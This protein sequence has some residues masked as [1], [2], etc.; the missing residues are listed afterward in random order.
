LAALATDERPT[1]LEIDVLHP[2]AAGNTDKPIAESQS[3]EL[4]Q[5]YADF[6][7]ST[8]PA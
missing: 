1:P 6:T 8:T 7:L 5:K 3:A 4:R 2:T